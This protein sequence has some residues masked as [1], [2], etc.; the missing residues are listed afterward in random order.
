[1]PSQSQTLCWEP[2]RKD[3]QDCVPAFMT[4]SE[5]QY[6][7]SISLPTI[8]ELRM[9]TQVFVS[10]TNYKIL[11]PYLDILKEHFTENRKCFH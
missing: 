2:E 8:S 10:I 6:I 7:T 11:S 1:M 4:Q 5:R 3:E 9:K